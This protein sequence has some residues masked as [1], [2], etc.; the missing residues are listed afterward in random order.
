VKTIG[1]CC[2]RLSAPKTNGTFTDEEK[3]KA[4]EYNKSSSLLPFNSWDTKMMIW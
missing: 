1:E 3:T 4:E 2:K